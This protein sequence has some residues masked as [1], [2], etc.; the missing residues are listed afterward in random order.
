[1]HKICLD[2]F[3]YRIGS[4]RYIRLHDISYSPS[5]L[6]RRTKTDGQ[7]DGRTEGRTEGFADRG[8][9]GQ[10]D[11]RTEGRADTGTGGHRDG[12]THPPI[13]RQLKIFFSKKRDFFNDFVHM[14]LI[15]IGHSSDDQS[16][17]ENTQVLDF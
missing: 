12:H 1:M 14:L 7:R 11:G 15:A 9:D 16:V 5:Y 6:A 3:F 13:E 10:R 4:H 17:N 8:T 2:G